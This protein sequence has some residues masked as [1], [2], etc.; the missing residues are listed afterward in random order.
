RFCQSQAHDEIREQLKGLKDRFEALSVAEPEMAIV[1]NCCQVRQAIEDIF[2]E[3]VVLLDVWHFMMRYMSC[4]VNGMKNPYRSAVSR[5]ITD[6]ILKTTADKLNRSEYWPQ[7]EQER[8]LQEAYEKWYRIGNVWNADAA[9]KHETQMAHV[10]KGCLARPRQDIATDGSRIEGTHKG[11]NSLQRSHSSGLETLLELCSDYVLRRNIR[12]GIALDPDQSRPFLRST[13][14]SHHVGLVDGIAKLWNRILARAPPKK[15]AGLQLFPELELVNSGEAFGL[16]HF[17]TDPSP[18]PDSDN[19]EPKP[20]L[21]D[22]SLQDPE[23]REAIM[24]DLHLDPVMLQRLLKCIPDGM[25]A[26][27]LGTSIHSAIIIDEDSSNS[28][29]NSSSSSSS[30]SNS[31]S[32]SSGGGGGGGG[33]GTASRVAAV[34]SS[35]KGPEV[36]QS[37]S[38]QEQVQHTPCR[39]PYVHPMQLQ[40]RPTSARPRAMT[41]LLAFFPVKNNASTTGA[42]LPLSDS[43]AALLQVLPKPSDGAP[44]LTRSARLFAISTGVNPQSLSIRDGPEWRAFMDLR[45]EKKWVSYDMKPHHWVLATQEYNRLLK[46][47]DDEAVEK[48]P[49]TL[50]EKLAKVE[51]EILRRLATGDYK[52]K[53]SGNEEFWKKH[54]EAVRLLYN[55][56]DRNKHNICQRCNAIMWPYPVGSDGNHSRG[57]CSDGVAQKGKDGEMLPSYPQPQGIFSSGNSFHAMPFLDMVREVYQRCVIEK[58]EN[59]GGRAMEYMAFISMLGARSSVRPDGSLLFKLFSTMPLANRNGLVASLIVQVDGSDHLRIDALGEVP[60][61]RIVEGTAE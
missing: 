8:R 42:A 29:S 39:C 26:K 35:T 6:A 36:V 47:D 4:I 3:I 24:K 2:P 33:G 12:I 52:A 13:Y 45:A 18:D 54:C 58:N 55:G 40:C 19:V 46:L 7:E 15:V 10:Q 41:G 43:A 53:G 9:E 48:V 60:Q 57:F 28:S 5:D 59:V 11:W 50:M 22:L 21:V 34:T 38:H 17:D 61:E 49:R 37:P 1:D 31:N 27:G 25:L 16:V 14:G 20:E 30:S 56:T 32:S 44:G 51:S 23:K